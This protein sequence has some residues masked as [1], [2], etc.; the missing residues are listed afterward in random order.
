[1]DDNNKVSQLTQAVPK[2][3]SSPTPIPAQI[4]SQSPGR[5]RFRVFHPHRQ[6]HQMEPIAKA[7]Q[8]HLEIY[9]VRSNVNSGSITVFYA[10]EYRTFADIYAILRDLG[11]IFLDVTGE[12]PMATG[13]KSEAATEVTKVA[14]DL[15]ERVKEATD[16]AVDLRFL[17]PLGFSALAVRQLLV[18]GLQFELIPWYVFAWYAFDS[19]F[20]LHYTS[21]PDAQATIK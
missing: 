12:N 7:L 5:I 18:K 2:K 21:D 19:F 9:R 20:K 3:E 16:G 10:R 4:V 8:E 17:V 14:N 15:N 13:N 11:L 6:K 1:M